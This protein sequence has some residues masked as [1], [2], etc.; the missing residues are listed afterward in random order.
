MNFSTLAVAGCGYMVGYA[1]GDGHRNLAQSLGI[2]NVDNI[3]KSNSSNT[4]IIQAVYQHS[5]QTQ[6]PVI[7]VVGM[8]FLGRWTLPLLKQGKS[9]WVSFQNSSNIVH[10]ED[11]AISLE[12][13]ETLLEI[14]LKTEQY[15][16]KDRLEHLIMQLRMLIDSLRARQHQIVIFNTAD[17]L[18]VP[19]LTEFESL[20]NIPQFVHNLAWLSVPWQFAQ[21]VAP[22][23][24]DQQPGIPPGQRHPNPGEH[25]ILN[26]FLLNYINTH[27]IA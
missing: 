25:E 9:K 24:Y 19:Y 7:Y 1:H 18:V 17:D 15:S 21:G 14:K 16:I 22:S 12:E 26:K 13:F 6:L 11:W 10:N 27:L 4:E 20:T 23:V 2:F 3:T 8:T 5:L